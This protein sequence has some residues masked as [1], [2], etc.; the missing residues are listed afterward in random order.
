MYRKICELA[1]LPYVTSFSHLCHAVLMRVDRIEE[2][3]KICDLLFVICT[4]QFIIAPVLN[5]LM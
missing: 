3:I 5:Y 1:E 4:C 2:R